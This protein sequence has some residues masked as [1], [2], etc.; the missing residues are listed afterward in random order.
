M[1]RMDHKGFNCSSH[2]QYTG[3]QYSPVDSL[4]ICVTFHCSSQSRSA[5][6]SIVLVPNVA[7]VCCRSCPGPETRTQA[8]MVSRCTSN[9]HT[10]SMITSRSPPLPLPG[11]PP[12]IR[13][14]LACSRLRGAVHLGVPL[15]PG[16]NWPTIRN[17]TEARPLL[18][19][20]LIP[21]SCFGVNPVHESWRERISESILGSLAAMPNE[22]HRPGGLRHAHHPILTNWPRRSVRHRCYDRATGCI[23]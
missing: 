14:Y 13:L 2:T 10:R 18:R 11:E 7:M 9:P 3:F 5:S 19:Q 21:F 12:P 20:W 16:S 23:P 8:L 15:A 4:A 22:Q 6:K 1:G 17:T